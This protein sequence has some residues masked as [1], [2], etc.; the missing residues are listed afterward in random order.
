VEALRATFYRIGFPWFITSH[1][2][3]N[4][5]LIE[6]WVVFTAYPWSKGLVVGGGID[7]RLHT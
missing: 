3:G 6:V 4:G 2:W 5:T 1:L 7:V